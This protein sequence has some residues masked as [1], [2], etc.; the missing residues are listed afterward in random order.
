M[1]IISKNIVEEYI[2]R[3]A[4]AKVPLWEW[5][6]K[7]TN[8]KWTCFRDMKETFNS[9]DYVGNNRYVFNVGGNRTRL[10]AI[11]EFEPSYV[12]IRKI[13]THAEYSKIKDIKNI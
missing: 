8:A 10:I 9:V 4:N 3:N 6:N 11:V 5:Y 12:R 13:C 7:V 2:R 1:I